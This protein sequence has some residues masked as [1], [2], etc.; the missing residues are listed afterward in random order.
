MRILRQAISIVY[1]LA[2]CALA[3][4]RYVSISCMAVNRRHIF[5]ISMLTSWGGGGDSEGGGTGLHS[6]KLII[7][8]LA[9]L[10]EY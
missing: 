2:R 3:T 4:L 1:Q 6:G 9:F 7:H 8:V 10:D 5:S